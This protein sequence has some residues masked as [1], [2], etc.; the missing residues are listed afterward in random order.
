MFPHLAGWAGTHAAFQLLKL[1]KLQFYLAAVILNL[2]AGNYIELYAK[3]DVA[4]GAVNFYHAF[5][6]GYKL[7]E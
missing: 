1:L 3:A 4:S 7:I 2:A 5:L 6:G